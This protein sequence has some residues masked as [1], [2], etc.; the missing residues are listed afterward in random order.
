MTHT[1]DSH[2]SWTSFL[3]G[4]HKAGNGVPDFNKTKGKGKKKEK[5]NK[6]LYELQ[7]FRTS[8]NNICEKFTSKKKKKN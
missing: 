7:H 4:L 3:L 1:Y 6:E 8:A 2:L 5:K